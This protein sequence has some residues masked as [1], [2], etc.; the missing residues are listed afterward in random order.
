MVPT[1]FEHGK[2]QALVIHHC[3]E[4]FIEYEWTGP[5]TLNFD[6][7]TNPEPD[8][9]GWKEG[10]PAFVIEIANTTQ[11]A[12]FGYKKALYEANGVSLYAALNLRTKSLMGWEL[13]DGVYRENP[14]KI[15]KLRTELFSGA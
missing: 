14:E 2:Y 4:H 8:V 12:D 13:E 10:V 1:G 7:K 5:V 6:D 11:K 15:M 9:I 3:I